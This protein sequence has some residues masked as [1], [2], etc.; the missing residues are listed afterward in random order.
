[1]ITLRNESGAAVDAKKK[2]NEVAVG[3][4]NGAFYAGVD[5]VL[6]LKE[7]ETGEGLE[8]I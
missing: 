7:C 8:R 5:T 1:M 3:R 4:I 2:E 6:Q